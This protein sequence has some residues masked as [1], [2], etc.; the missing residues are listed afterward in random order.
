[1]SDGSRIPRRIEEFNSY[2]A[3]TSAYLRAGTPTNAER[4]GILTDECAQWVAFST[5]WVPLYVR[6]SDKKNSRT[7]AIKDQL[8]LIINECTE[9]DR[10][11]RL[12]DRIAASPNV[13]ITDME[14]FNI[15]K[16]VLQKT[17]RT[18][19]VTPISEPVVAGI[20]PIGGGS[21][22]IKCHTATGRRPSI[23]G[24]A[25]CVQ[26]SYQVG[27]APPVAADAAGLSR[28]ISTKASFILPLGPENSAKYLYIFFQ[29]YNTKHPELAGPWSLMQTILI[30]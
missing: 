2:I 16:G 5:E 6:Y 17:T 18:V 3:N 13:T 30:L 7:T 27:G 4:L 11:C 20:Q 8:M 23:F 25:N 12:L 1:M 9:L 10:S 15:K 22:S 29:W 14:T 28:G 26:Y 21:V 24:E 19:P